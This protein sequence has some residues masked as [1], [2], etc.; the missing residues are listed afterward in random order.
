MITAIPATKQKD[1]RAG[2]S[3]SMP[4]KKANDS[5]KAAQK[6]EGPISFIA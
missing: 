1:Q 4:T 6:I 3:V 5:Q 2:T